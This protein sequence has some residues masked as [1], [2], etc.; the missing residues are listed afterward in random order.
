[1]NRFKLPALFL[2]LPLAA[3]AADSLPAG[4]E[5]KTVQRVCGACH[6]V[7]VFAGKEH[8]RQEWADIVNEMENAGAKA[9]PA[10]FRRIVAYLSRNFPKK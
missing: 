3:P 2:L 7:E 10:E 9:T 5:R 6:D 4:P 1:M 8:S